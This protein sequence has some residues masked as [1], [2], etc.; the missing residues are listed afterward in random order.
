M[1]DFPRM[2]FSFM[3]TYVRRNLSVSEQLWQRK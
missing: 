2:S 1:I 3:M